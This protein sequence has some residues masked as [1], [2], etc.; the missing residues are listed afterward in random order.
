VLRHEAILPWCRRNRQATMR[1]PQA[2]AKLT[3]G[4]F[5]ARNLAMK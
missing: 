2:Q 5:L 4:T 1:A 3:Q